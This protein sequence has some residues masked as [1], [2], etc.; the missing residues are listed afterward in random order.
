MRNYYGG[1]HIQRSKDYGRNSVNLNAKIIE[2]WLDEKVILLNDISYK[3][4]D[5]SIK[6]EGEIRKILKEYI[7]VASR[8]NGFYIGICKIN[9]LK[10]LIIRNKTNDK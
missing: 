2:Q 4:K 6:H 3:L 5:F 8:Y 7:N 1:M 10:P 9:T